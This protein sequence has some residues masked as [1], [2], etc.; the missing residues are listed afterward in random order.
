[1]FSASDPWEDDLPRLDNENPSF[2]ALLSFFNLRPLGCELGLSDAI[3]T[4][5]FPL[6]CFGPIGVPSPSVRFMNRG[7]PVGQ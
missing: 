1:M 6:H 5:S 4:S 3:E 2:V 7:F